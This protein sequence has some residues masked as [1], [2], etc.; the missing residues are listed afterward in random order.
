MSLITAYTKAT[1]TQGISDSVRYMVTNRHYDKIVRVTTT[2]TAALAAITDASASRRYML[3]VPDGTYNEED[4]Q[5]KSYVDIV[6]ESQDGVIIQSSSGLYDTIYTGGVNMMLSNLTVNH[7]FNTGDAGNAQYPIHADAGTTDGSTFTIPANSTTIYYKVKVNSLGTAS[8]AALGIGLSGGQR[9]Y[10]VDSEFTSQTSVGIFAHNRAYPEDASANLP[11]G[12]YIINTIAT[13]NTYGFIWQN[14]GSTSGAD[15]IAIFGGS[16][17]GGTFDI[18]AVDVITGGNHGAGEAYFYIDPDVTYNTIS[19]VDP[20]K[21]LTTPQLLSVPTQSNPLYAE[22]SG[23]TFLKNS[24]TNI[25][26]G[27]LGMNTLGKVAIGSASASAHPLVVS[28]TSTTITGYFSN[29]KV[30]GTTY[31]GYFQNSLNAGSGD[32]YGIAILN[33]STNSGERWGIHISGEARNHFSGKISTQGILS[34]SEQSTLPTP[35]SGY[36]SIYPKTDGLWYGKDD[37]GLETM[38]SNPDLSGYQ[39]TLVSGTNIKT[40]NGS[41]IL[42]SGDIVI[43]GASWTTLGSDIY[44]NSGL[45]GIGATTAPTSKLHI[46]TAALGV[47]QANSSG[48][49]LENTTAA[50]AAAQQISPVF[51]QRGRG[52]KTTA[53]AASQTVDFLQDV[54]PVEGTTAPSGTWRLGKSIAGGAVTY[55]LTVTSAGVVTSLGMIVGVSMNSGGSF[56]TYVTAVS[57]NFYVPAD[58]SIGSIASSTHLIGGAG[59]IYFR[60]AFYGSSSSTLIAN[61]AFGA[62]ILASSPVTTA[63]TG[64]HP[65]FANLVVKPI[66]TIT[67]GGSAL[68]NTASVYIEDAHTSGTNNYALWSDAGTNRL[69]GLMILGTAAEHTDNA[70]A[71]TAGLAVGSIYKTGDVLKI[72]HA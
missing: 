40:L 63:A 9:I 20:S 46:I 71:V 41:T 67:S 35:A 66:G 68:T 38:L 37:A 29:Y 25:D 26:W 55:P 24:A 15:R 72:V 61:N 33:N 64:T 51:I 36:A 50:A 5:A 45:V 65:I 59:T 23:L 10:I 49:M 18:I 34:I 53:T 21:L 56:Q 27:T 70:A 2:I 4:I 54:L 52:W 6:G 19:L 48:I 22:Y 13:G 16:Y 62:V 58:R 1:A 7:T 43:T 8:S 31:A 3:Y 69:D 30:S 28:N 14:S 39:A 57:S 17:S 32:S 11:V 60:A 42:G 44:Y 47:A 12:L